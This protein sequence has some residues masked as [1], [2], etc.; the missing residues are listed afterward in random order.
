MNDS[1]RCENCQHWK[2]RVAEYEMSADEQFEPMDYD[3]MYD[4]KDPPPF[5][6]EVRYC[7]SPKLLFLERPSSRTHATV[8]DGSGY[9]AH[10]FTG[11]DFVCAN[12]E[13]SVS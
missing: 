8:V 9:R 12:W 13:R 4:G 1:R 2:H 5:A 10:L 11:P 3:G 6:F 7:A